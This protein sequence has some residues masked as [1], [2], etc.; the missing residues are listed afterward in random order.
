MDMKFSTRK[1]RDCIQPMIDT[2]QS[3]GVHDQ[4]LYD[5][6]HEVL[7]RLLQCLSYRERGAGY[8]L[9]SDMTNEGFNN[10]IGIDLQTGFVFGR[11]QWNCGTWMDQMESSDRAG[12]KGHP[13]TPRDGSA[14]ELVAL[15]RASLSWLVQMNEDK[16]YP[17]NSV[18]IT[19]GLSPF[20]CSF[21]GF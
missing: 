15:L 7:L 17:Y 21:A 5:V 1:S 6:I 20:S 2:Y 8:S 14:I 12:N 18:E 16:H 11:N 10:Q 4:C 9:D 19:S 13:A 3:M